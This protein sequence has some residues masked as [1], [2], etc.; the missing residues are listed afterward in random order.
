MEIHIIGAGPAGLIT[1]LRLVENNDVTIYEKRE[2]I[3][4]SPC[5][6][7]VSMNS[8]GILE[9]DVDF[10]PRPYISKKV[11]GIELNY[12]G[13]HAAHIDEEG[14][15]LNRTEWE[16]EMAKEFEKQ[17]GDLLLGEKIDVDDLSEIRREDSDVII[18]A[19][20]PSSVT[21]EYI[22]GEARIEEIYYS[23]VEHDTSDMEKS[24]FYVD[25]ELSPY[26]L[27]IFP[28]EDCVSLGG[29]DKEGAKKLAEREGI[30]G[31]VIEEGH[32]VDCVGNSRLE[33][34]N[35]YLIGDA[36]ST[37]NP[38][39]RSGLTSI[40]KSSKILRET[41]EEG[42]PYEERIKS[43]VT[44]DLDFKGEKIIKEISNDELEK[45]GSY[46]DGEN[47]FDLSLYK[48]LG[49]LKLPRLAGKMRTMREAYKRGVEYW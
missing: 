38:Y 35:I 20:G 36:A 39:T 7:C 41:V 37:R 3:E 12:P 1:G 13:G 11:K 33:K 40:I 42:K 48:K 28:K 15:V 31:E 46:I 45:I 26:Y 25:K 8:L 19:D 49:A 9:R 22:G 24:H 23:W 10:D 6:E 2:K 21:R 16:K 18:G 47:I 34:D 44:T 17:G 43:K 14:A 29:M 5:A 32:W 27:W 30:D 4:M